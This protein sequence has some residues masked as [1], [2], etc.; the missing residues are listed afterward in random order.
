MSSF[1]DGAMVIGY[2]VMMFII[3]IVIYKK[4]KELR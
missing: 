1:V 2:I 4:G 3:G